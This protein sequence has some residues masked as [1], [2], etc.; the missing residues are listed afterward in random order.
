MKLLLTAAL[1]IAAT[2]AIAADWHYVGRSGPGMVRYLDADSIR[3]SGNVVAF[4]MMIVKEPVAAGADTTEVLSV[5]HCTEHAYRILEQRRNPTTTLR[6]PTWVV[7]MRKEWRRFGDE[8]R[9]RAG[10]PIRAII[11]MACG[12]KPI[13]APA[14]EQSF[15]EQVAPAPPP[16]AAAPPTPSPSAALPA[17]AAAAPALPGSETSAP[18][19]A[20]AGPSAWVDLGASVT[21]QAI[22][23][24]A[25]RIEAEGSSPTAW[26]RLINPEE[27]DPIPASY[28]LRVDCAAK[29]INQLGL[30]RHGPAGAVTEQRDFGPEGEGAVPIEAETVME[31]AYR[32]LCTGEGAK[33]IRRLAGLPTDEPEPKAREASLASTGVSP[34][35]E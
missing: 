33:A 1:A 8:A 14:V 23:I 3:K 29:T 9:T 20:F 16:T 4:W 13:G 30:R 2:P 11:D 12:A 19:D 34:P 6:Q 27:E 24:D 17:P 15:A 25:S 32:G 10:D 31:V 5:A 22:L 35:S 7:T 26:F 21:G 18:A 28:L